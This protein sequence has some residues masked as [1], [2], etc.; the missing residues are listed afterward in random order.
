MNTCQ[1]R[2]GWGDGVR[3]SDVQFTDY[4]LIIKRPIT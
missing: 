3:D 1:G 2:L 4:R